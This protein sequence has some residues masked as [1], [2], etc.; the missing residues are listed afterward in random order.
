[1]TRQLDR[2]LPTL[3]EKLTECVREVEWHEFKPTIPKRRR[4]SASAYWD[5][6][7]FLVARLEQAETGR[8]EHPVIN[9]CV[10]T[11]AMPAKLVVPSYKVRGVWC[12]LGR[13]VWFIGEMYGAHC[14][15]PDGVT[16]GM[17]LYEQMF[18]LIRCPTHDLW[19]DSKLHCNY[20]ICVFIHNRLEKSDIF[21]FFILLTF[22]VP[23]NYLY[24]I[25]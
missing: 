25:D 21:F 6:E 12:L 16:R 13:F 9:I 2:Q 23:I 3:L 20:W 11:S 4:R 22:E 15:S 18:G 24:T 10:N 17:Q 8:T 5:N 1:M 14:F 7:P 19:Y